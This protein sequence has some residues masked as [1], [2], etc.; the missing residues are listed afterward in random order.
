MDT[1]Q[2]IDS[3]FNSQEIHS[4]ETTFTIGNGYLGTRGTFEEHYPGEQPATLINGLY[5]DTPIV[6]TELANT[7]NWLDFSLFIGSERFRLDVGEVLGFQRTLDLRS[8][9][10]S[11]KLRWQSPAGRVIDLEIERFASLADEHVLGI[12]CRV[13]PV[14]FTGTL[15]FRAGLPGQADNAGLFHWEWVDQGRMGEHSAFLQVR[16]R[17]SEISLCEACHLGILAGEGS[18]YDY[19]DTR[20]SPTLVARVTARP[21]VEVTAEKIVT[22][23][24]SR[25]TADPR[26]AAEE[27]LAAAVEHGYHALRTENDLAW[28][29]EW[30]RCSITIEGDDEADRA[31]RYNLFQLLIAAPRH[32]DRVS[33]PART[34][35]GFGYRGHIFWDTEIFILPAFIFTFPD[36]ARNLLIYRYRTLPGARLKA[37]SYGYEGAMYAW[38]S[39]ATGEDATPQWVPGQAGQLIRIWCGEIEQHISAD[40]A[41]AVFQYW[42]VTGDRSF[43]LDY[44]A[45]ILLET[46]RFWGSRAA[47]NPARACYEIK[48]VIGPDENHEHVDNNVFTNHMARWNLRRALEVMDWMR[49][50]VPGKALEL[51][52]RLDLSPQR[53]AHWKDVVEKIYLGLDPQ[54]G[55]YEQFEGFFKRS[56]INLLDYEPRSQS[57][58]AILGVEQTQNYQVLKQ[59][60]VMMLFYILDGDYAPQVVKANAAYYT[61]RTDF[62]YGS[63][64]GPAIQAILTARMGD[65]ESAYQLFLKT[66]HTDLQNSR[67][68]ASDGIHAASA[69]GLWQA[70]VFGFAGLKVTPDGPQVNP[71]LPARWKRMKFRIQYQGR[72]YD[73]DLSPEIQDKK[74]LRPEF[75]LLGAIFD[76]DGVLTDTSELHFRAWKRLADEEGI[77]FTRQDNEALRGVSRQESLRHLLKG[78][79]LPEDH[80]QAWMDRKNRYYLGY[81]EHLSFSDLL[82][83]ALKLLHELRAAGVKIAIGSASKNARLVVNNLGI[84]GLVDAISDGSSVERQK[85]APDLFLHAAA[86]LG[87]PPAQ[88]VVFEDAEVGVTAALAGGMWA[89]GMGPEER[90]GKAHIVLPG[91]ENASWASIL[92]LLQQA[93]SIN[94]ERLPGQ[95][96]T[97]PFSNQ[98]AHSAKEVNQSREVYK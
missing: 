4:K 20:W 24:A 38:E 68:N 77:L 43:M 9:V 60:D 11:R 8:G 33:I 69:G 63:S 23:Y 83:G 21:G 47:W 89:V 10:L 15:E 94:S 74:N 80:M 30:E 78:R 48:D 54:T 46:A 56:D 88:C 92:A 71:N 79:Q 51:E 86:Q 5:D 6:H 53:L 13:T 62:S 7:P 37:A 45:E 65:V 90:V 26:K 55:L 34:L 27:K 52:N 49:Q 19:W 87:V 66:L 22:V 50:A 36:V 98:S 75:P 17:A 58:Q 40:V 41:F 32:D 59:P 31:L 97:G 35:S 1:W 2:I 3:G 67:G 64:L 28:A 82:P 16:T 14:D 39:A 81:L 96:S 57:L 25:D 61:P 91:L 18:A 76:L 29:R 72:Q 95:L 42:R 12:R 70:A 93:S 84:A 73:F 44:G 85:P